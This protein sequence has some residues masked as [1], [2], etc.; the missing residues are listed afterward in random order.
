[1]LEQRKID[2]KR[3]GVSLSYNKQVNE[4]P[5]LKKGLP[6]FKE[7]YSQV[8]QNVASRLEEALQGF[9]RRWISKIHRWSD[10]IASPIR[11]VDIG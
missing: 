9:F 4:L 2:Y 6:E 10:M 5:D 8:L 1:M 7:I 3:R 11:K